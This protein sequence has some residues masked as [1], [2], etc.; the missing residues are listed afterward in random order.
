MREWW[1]NPL[2]TRNGHVRYID[3]QHYLVHSSQKIKQNELLSLDPQLH[4][5][6]L[7]YNFL[8]T[9][10]PF[11]ITHIRLR[12]P[13]TTPLLHNM[14]C[15]LSILRVPTDVHMVLPYFLT[16]QNINILNQSFLQALSHTQTDRQTY[17]MTNSQ[18]D[19]AM[20][21]HQDLQ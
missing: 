13:H 4:I 7:T 2:G 11:H 19:G 21:H 6:D 18:L 17:S 15:T 20:C 16:T 14:H 1:D 8:Y 9:S 10:R 3:K 12:P 5:P